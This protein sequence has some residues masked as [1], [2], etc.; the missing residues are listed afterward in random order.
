MQKLS[1]MESQKETRLVREQDISGLRGNAGASYLI[2]QSW[3]RVLLQRQLPSWASQPLETLAEGKASA[4]FLTLTSCYCSHFLFSQC[5][6]AAC[7]LLAAQACILFDPCS[8]TKTCG[9][10]VLSSSYPVL[11][12]ILFVDLTIK[13]P[14]STSYPLKNLLKL[15]NINPST[16]LICSYLYAYML[17]EGSPQKSLF[18]YQNVLSWSKI[19]LI[20]YKPSE[21]LCFWGEEG[22]N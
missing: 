11:Y 16:S 6:K 22:I 3:S 19:S 2:S 8:W 1:W 17:S 20:F 21:K 12:F 9:G 4:V 13:V 5:L 18:E 10:G 7:T 15:C 14:L